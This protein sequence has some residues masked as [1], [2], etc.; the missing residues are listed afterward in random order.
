MGYVQDPSGKKSPLRKPV[1]SP[2]I[3]STSLNSR[4]CIN[5]HKRKVR[6]DRRLP[7]A[8]CDRVGWACSYPSADRHLSRKAAPVQDITT[9]LERIETIL[10]R[11][12]DGNS[13]QDLVNIK[14][15]NT[16]VTLKSPVH[17]L[18][19]NSSDRKPWEVL[20]KN[21]N[22]VHYVDNENLLNL[23]QDVC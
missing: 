9:R 20:L 19:P 21:G 14:Q 16:E 4:S 17:P 15:K 8:Q 23:F 1:M 11:L 2:G 18:S 3:P 13:L 12:C 10:L 22:R 6:C 5:C 7:C